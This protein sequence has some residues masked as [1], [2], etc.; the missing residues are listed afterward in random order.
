M[1]VPAGP[2]GPP[3]RPGL[4]AWAK[5]NPALAAAAA[6]A[7]G[8]GLWVLHKRSV[9]NTP[10]D[11][12]GADATNTPAGTIPGQFDGSGTTDPFGTVEQQIGDLQA[13]LGRFTAGQNPAPAPGLN[14][15]QLAR[16]ILIKRGEK[17]PTQAEI[18]K[19]RRRLIRLLGPAPARKPAPRRRPAGRIV[20]GRRR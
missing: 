6:A 11:T 1:T 10:A 20:V 12:A 4:V 5:K 9:A 2:P 15:W 18:G 3:R 13:Q 8:L 17:N 7:G 16:Q 19:E 14:F